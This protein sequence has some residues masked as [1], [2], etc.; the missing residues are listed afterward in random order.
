[1]SVYAFQTDTLT[2]LIIAYIPASKKGYTYKNCFKLRTT[3]SGMSNKTKEHQLYQ[4]VLCHSSSLTVSAK[5]K[6]TILILFLCLQ[7]SLPWNHIQPH[8][9]VE[10]KTLVWLLKKQI[11][12]NKH[13]NKSEIKYKVK[14]NAM[15]FKH[16]LKKPL[17]LSFYHVLKLA[18]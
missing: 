6:G 1:M 2:R 11:W 3:I 8:C 17:L 15:H 16:V 9:R 7:Q 10:G 12:A 13:S 18:I 14:G 4:N 5:I